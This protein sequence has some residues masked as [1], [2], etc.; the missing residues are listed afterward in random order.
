[1]YFDDVTDFDEERKDADSADMTE[2]AISQEA[3]QAAPDTE[4]GGT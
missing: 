2:D 1:M 3:S 4:H